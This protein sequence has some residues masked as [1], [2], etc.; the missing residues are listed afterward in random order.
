MLNL[1]KDIFV[2][3]SACEYSSWKS[4]KLPCRYIFAVRSKL[5]IEL[6]DDILCDKRWSTWYKENQRI[7]CDDASI[8]HPDVEIVQLPILGREC[9]YI[10]ACVY[11]IICIML[12]MQCMVTQSCMCMHRASGPMAH[13][14]RLQYHC[15]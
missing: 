14:F 11:L 3:I 6:F 12:S 8:D 4:M 7:F 9:T 13:N 15:V 5:G 2:T 1:V 10:H